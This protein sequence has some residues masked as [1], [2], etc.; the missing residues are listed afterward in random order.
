MKVLLTTTPGLGHI[1]PLLPLVR[2]LRA[3]GHEL[4]WVGGHQGL[5]DIS[6]LGIEVVPAGMPELE[7]QQE[8][9]RR[10]PELPSVPEEH[11]QVFAFPKVF[12]ELAAP[13]M[14]E[15]VREVVERWAPD[16]IVHD[17][18]ELAAPLIAAA[19]GIP[20]ACHAFGQVVP[21]EGAREAGD[22]M[23]PHWRAAGLEPDPFAGS[24]RGL[25]IDVYPPS[26]RS[27]EMD[28]IPRVQQC[29]PAEG[30]PA[31][32]T[33]VY[34]TFGTLF[35]RRSDALRT[36][37]LAAASV[38]EDVLVTVGRGADPGDLGPVPTHVR[39]EHFVPQA[40]VLPTCAAVVCHGGSGTLLAAL[41]HGIPVVC[42]PQGADQFANAANVGRL[43]AGVAVSGSAADG[44]GL[45]EA[46][47][48]VLRDPGPRRAAR[49]LAQEIAGM[50][51]SPETG[52]AIEALVR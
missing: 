52:R 34:V 17:A 23:A 7:R 25:Y 4:R 1:L 6:A 40:E 30:R 20:S 18:A 26:L 50:P 16:V 22:L 43:G 48:Q 38:A 9:L 12:A 10:H 11:R 21:A 24:Y 27:E 47:A 29:R 15:P 33:T 37:V 5:D 14:L 28:H 39:V 41:A 32:G 2:E 44:P 36:A 49:Q 13:A 46:T 3:R 51:G 45:G 35:N 42:V 8:L 31:S 19:A